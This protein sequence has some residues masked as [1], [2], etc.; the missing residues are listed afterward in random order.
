MINV[1]ELLHFAVAFF[2]LVQLSFHAHSWF[3]PTAHTCS[4]TGGIIAKLFKSMLFLLVQEYKKIVMKQGI[5]ILAQTMLNPVLCPYLWWKQKA[6]V[7]RN[8]WHNGEE[9]QPSCIMVTFWNFFSYS[10][11]K[12]SVF[13]GHVI[14]CSIPYPSKDQKLVHSYHHILPSLHA[15]EVSI[16]EI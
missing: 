8:C 2:F 5:Y 11:Q 9:I 4:E 7:S 14:H 13:L 3:L 16:P 1:W 12:G 10:V 15:S 6:F